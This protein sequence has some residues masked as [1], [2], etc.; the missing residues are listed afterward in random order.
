[1]YKGIFECFYNKI[2]SF[3]LEENNLLILHSEA[4][5][6]FR[7]IKNTRANNKDTSSAPV[8]CAKT[9]MLKISE[10]SSDGLPEVSFQTA[11]CGPV[12]GLKLR[13]PFP[14]CKPRYV[15]CCVLKCIQV[16]AACVHVAS[17]SLLSE[18]CSLCSRPALLRSSRPAYSERAAAE[19]KRNTLKALSHPPTRTEWTR[20]AAVRQGADMHEVS[21]RIHP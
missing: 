4:F 18:I 1:M 20:C 16:R 19:L 11:H 6:I 5:L 21:A 2:W 10:V 9:P 15:S 14:K 7:P 8:R 3:L 12:I 13:V 17:V